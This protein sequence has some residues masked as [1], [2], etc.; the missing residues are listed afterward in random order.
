MAVV[1]R[2]IRCASISSGGNMEATPRCSVREASLFFAGQIC[3]SVWSW[4]CFQAMWISLGYAAVAKSESLIW[5]TG[6]EDILVKLRPPKRSW[7]T[8]PV[9][10]NLKTWLRRTGAT[11]SKIS[12][13]V[14]NIDKVLKHSMRINVGLR[15][16]T[17]YWSC[18]ATHMGALHLWSKGVV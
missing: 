2:S 13:P 12:R 11:C 6:V 3:S 5:I 1:H 7:F 10:R 9:T 16:S 17:L 4:A 14:A 15:P 18:D 8:V